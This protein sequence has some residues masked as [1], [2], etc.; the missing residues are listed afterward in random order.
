MKRTIALSSAALG[1]GVLLALAAPLS[2][3]AHVT[4]SASTTAAGSYSVLTF[5]V[6]HG[7]DGSPTT[8]VAISLP[9]TITTATPTVNPNWTISKVTVPLDEP[10]A[11]E[12]GDEITE[13][14]SQ[15][16]YTAK[17]PL[18]ADQRDT[19]ALSLALVGEEGDVLEFPT[20]QTCEVGETNWAG[21]EVPAVTLTAA[22]EGDGHHGGATHADGDH[23]DAD[24]ADAAHDETAASGDDVLARGLGIAGL[25]VGAVGVVIGVT[26]RRRSA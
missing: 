25:V 4:V 16:V 11:E 18:A 13:R 20:L 7:C 3:S 17:T 2:A 22:A 12:D 10:I 5:S 1:A 15:I 6:G 21:E 23:A 9:E 8:T 24:H 26:A 14:V 19:F